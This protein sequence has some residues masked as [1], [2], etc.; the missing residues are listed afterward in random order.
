ME[1]RRNASAPVVFTNGV[2]D[3]LHSGHLTLLEAAR[4]EGASLIVAI[5][6]DQSVAGLGKSG[7]RPII[8]QDDR[9][10]IVAALKVV[11]RVIIFDEQTPL[12]L[13]EALNP[14][15]LVKGGDYTPDTVVG[16]EHVRASGGRVVIV[17][18]LPNH[19][20][21][22]ILERLRGPS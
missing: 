18:L 15:V 3:L 21:T 16:A 17:P 22:R 6:S 10:R 9:A 7:D 4:A 13:I 1:W 20:T 8:R 5:N 2:F 19:S 12:H 11:D 14:D